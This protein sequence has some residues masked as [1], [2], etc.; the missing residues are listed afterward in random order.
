MRNG[1]EGLETAKGGNG[2]GL[3]EPEDALIAEPPLR[4]PL[5][6]PLTDRNAVEH[7]AEPPVAVPSQKSPLYKRPLAIALAIVAILVGA[8]AAGAYWVYASQFE[9]TDDAFLDGHVIAISPKVAAEVIAVQVNDNQLVKKGDVLVELDPRDFQV[10]LDAA[11]AA[12]L[13]AEGKLQQAQSQLHT[14]QAS[15][16]EA[17][18]E[19]SVAEAEADRA[20][21]DLRRYRQTSGNAISAQEVTRAEADAKTTAAQVE[22]AKR[23]ADAAQSDVGNTESSI[24]T[25]Q[26]D[27]EEAK[28]AVREAELN[29]SYTRILAPEN[30]RVTRKSIEPGSYVQV[31]QNVLSIVP[32]ET[33]VVANFK[34]TQLTEMRPGQSADVTVDAYPDHVFHGHLESIQSGTGARFSLLPPENATGNY[35]KVVQRVP[36]KIVLD[37]KPDD[38]Y[39]LA[40]GMSAV[41]EVKVK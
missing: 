13:A 16:D 27:V 1:N 2:T 35:V 40:P 28:V 22:A 21:T 32:P 24:T 11:K 30:G 3:L 38:R 34:E 41:P 33:W 9:S 20:A 18:A 37:D 4:A 39:I 7:A 23:K 29:L 14:S 36:V 10:K 12:E 6:R 15:A 8:G 5:Q 17:V 26:A 31:G 19:V 25:A